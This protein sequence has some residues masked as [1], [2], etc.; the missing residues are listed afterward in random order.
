MSTAL[1]IVQL[2]LGPLA[3]AIIGGIVVHFATQRR[4]VANDRRKQQVDY[5][6][7]AYRALARTAHRTFDRE[8]A[9][10]FETAIADIILLGNPEQITLAH[11]CIASFA[12]DGGVALD[13]LLLSLRASLR[14]ELNLEQADLDRIPTIRIVFDVRQPGQPVPLGQSES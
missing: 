5:L 11:R 9:V 12:A 6:V 14:Q 13:E 3:G 1:Q 10:A 2:V 8:Q 4:D 7:N